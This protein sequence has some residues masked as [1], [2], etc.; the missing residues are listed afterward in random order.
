MTT[1]HLKQFMSPAATWWQ[2]ADLYDH[3]SVQKYLDTIMA[4]PR[5]GYQRTL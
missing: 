2:P 4:V 1:P 3:G 5:E